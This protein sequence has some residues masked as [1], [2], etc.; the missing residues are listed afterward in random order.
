MTALSGEIQFLEAKSCS[1]QKQQNREL[2]ETAGLAK[3]VGSLFEGKDLEIYD[4]RKASRAKN[5][6]GFHHGKR[7]DVYSGKD[8]SLKEFNRQ[9]LPQVKE[10]GRL[11][12]ATHGVFRDFGESGGPALL[13]STDPPG[14]YNWLTN[15]QIAELPLNADV[16]ALIA[17]DSGRGQLIPGEGLTSMG[18]AFQQAGS[19]TVLMSLWSTDEKASTTMAKL[20]F[21]KVHE[22]KSKLEAFQEA[23]QELRNANEGDFAHPIFWAPFIMVGEAGSVT[24]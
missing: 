13:L 14:S 7:V 16:A 21:S 17:C 9:I 12:F 6:P 15:S 3:A 8:A 18:R 5:I 23:R 22:G 11:L 24:H 1:D 19:R 10:Y 4:G 2:P 20:F